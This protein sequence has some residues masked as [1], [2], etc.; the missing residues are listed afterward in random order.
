MPESL[1]LSRFTLGPFEQNCYLLV[2]PSGRRAA[3]VDPGVGSESLLETIEQRSLTLDWI[4]NT[5]AHLDHVAGNAAFKERSDARLAIH[6]ADVDLLMD[7]PGQLRALQSAGLPLRLDLAPSP[8]P[9]V[10]LEEGRCVPF[11]GL[12]LEV[13][14][15]P[16][17]SP[18]GVCLRFGDR[19]LVGD[20][21][22]HGSIGRTDLPGGSIDEL[23][24]SVRQKLFRLPPETVCYP[25]H[26]PETT[27]GQ[28]RRSNPFVSDAVVGTAE[29][30]DPM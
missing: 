14:H 21:L 7:L 16:G 18:G 3:V 30:A 8:A 28:E 17:H 20:T 26:G 27:L 24:G 5:H 6:S 10:L 29:T 11:D 12:E 22:F 2:G 25:G 1:R 4:L 19:M 23:V 15:T 13:I 9:D